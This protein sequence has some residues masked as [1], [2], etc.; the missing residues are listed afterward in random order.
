MVAQLG[1][2]ALGQSLDVVIEAQGG[3]TFEFPFLVTEYLPRGQRTPYLRLQAT[4][5]DAARIG[6]AFWRDGP[7][8][9]AA[10]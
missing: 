6:S 2:L 9:P 7:E 3:S 10:G 5:S 4:G 1:P 8:P